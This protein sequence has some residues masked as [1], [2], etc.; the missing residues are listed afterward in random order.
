MKSQCERGQDYCG[1]PDVVWLVWPQFLK[2]RNPSQM[3]LR[4]GLHGWHVVWQNIFYWGIFSN[5]TPGSQE[6]P[7]ATLKSTNKTTEIINMLNDSLPRLV[8]TFCHPAL[9]K[10]MWANILQGCGCL[11]FVVG[12]AGVVAD[13]LVVVVSCVCCFELV[14]CCVVVLCML[15]CVVAFVC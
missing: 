4:A 2:K 9:W 13:L 11:V 14:R 8:W 12:V 7:K 15:L 6:A 5:P 10:P 3:G 1:S